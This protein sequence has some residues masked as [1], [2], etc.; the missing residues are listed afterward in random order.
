[1]KTLNW[2]L[3]ALIQNFI[4]LLPSK[5]SYELYF[6]M[7]KYFGGLKKPFNPMNHFSA[8]VSMVKKIE[9]FTGGGGGGGKRK[10][11]F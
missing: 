1:M 7:Q 4:D 5:I 11:I 9:Q 3:K 10:K 2:K 6:Q 8:A